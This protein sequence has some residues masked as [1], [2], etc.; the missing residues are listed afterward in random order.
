MFLNL[1]STSRHHIMKITKLNLFGL[2]LIGLVLIS[3]CAKETSSSTGW[4]YNNYE[5]G[6]F[7]RERQNRE[8]VQP[9]LLFKIAIGI[10]VLQPSRCGRAH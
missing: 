3:S 1:F 2:T 7:E 4:E 5:N 9:D 8:F 10:G 6:G